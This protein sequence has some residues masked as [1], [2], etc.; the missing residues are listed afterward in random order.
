VW[1]LRA[2][3]D[4]RFR[5]GHPW[6]Y[7]NELAHSPR[8]AAQRP[9]A[10]GD[11]VE[12]RDAAG[13]FLARGYGH[14]GTLIAFRALSRDP[15]EAEPWGEAA[16][17]ARLRRAAALRHGLGLG[18]V[19]HR[20]VFGEADDLPGLVVDRYRLAPPD[21]AAGERGPAGIAAQVLAVQAHTAGAER[22]QEP[23]LAALEA[24]VTEEHAADPR[25]PDWAHTAVVLR[26]DAGARRLEGLPDD[27]VRVA[28]PGP[29]L[30]LT[31]ARVLTA[32]VAGDGR[33]A[34][35]PGPAVLQADL[36]GGQKTGLFLDQAANLRLAAGLLAA[37]LRSESGSFGT[38]G[39]MGAT[40]APGPMGATA[41]PG[42]MG[43]T[44]APGP[45]GATAA[46]G[47]MGA[48]AAPGPMGATAAPL[49]ILDL[50]AYVGAWGAALARVGAAAG[51]AVEVTV[52]DASAPALAL[53]V[54]NVTAA[55]GAC[56]PL[57]ADV[58]ADAQGPLA[59]AQGPL[60][61][62]PPG[63]FD[64]VVADPPAFIKGRKAWHTGRA[65]YVKL[66]TAA[67]RWVRPGGLLVTCSC[68]QLLSE[69]DFLAVLDK[70][71]ARAGTPVR[72]IARGGQAPDHP[73][74]AGFPEGDY[75]K[76]RIGVVG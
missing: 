23:L 31:P 35:P 69:A 56:T 60:A 3:A 59:D 73:V 21:A 51:R 9:V 36:L 57:R 12:L 75:L 33:S 14:P 68:S 70:A 67:L 72:W 22:L 24:L 28:R 4:K 62:L 7:S 15:A 76:A 26:N 55:G 58:L 19:S 10:P 49:R 20:L 2:G 27:A 66:N 8:G 16:L 42:P 6:V 71:A 46:P 40:A 44:A 39:P 63:G 47:P 17:L 11:P 52:V 45:M 37:R 18:A 30:A 41:A 50:F 61:A 13:R 29:G 1:T 48:T 74:R 54:A 53:A 65:A 38:P 43:A 5:A 64:V 25:H 32:P 34:G